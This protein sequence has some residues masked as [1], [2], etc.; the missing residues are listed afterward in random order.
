MRV[1][2]NTLAETLILVVVYFLRD[3]F[4]FLI[5]SSSSLC[6][7]L[8]RLGVKEAYGGLLL[9]VHF[10][11]ILSLVDHRRSVCLHRFLLDKPAKVFAIPD[12]ACRNFYICLNHIKGTF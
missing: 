8:A 10:R 3:A 12:Q 9:V 4:N 6:G 1:L 5:L 2:P 7:P 11:F